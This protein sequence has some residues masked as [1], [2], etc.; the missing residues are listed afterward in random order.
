VVQI[1]IG[2]VFFSDIS[3]ISALVGTSTPSTMTAI[4]V[5]SLIMILTMYPTSF[6]VI[7]HDIE[8]GNSL[9]TIISKSIVSIPRTLEM[10]RADVSIHHYTYGVHGGNIRHLDTIHVESVDGERI[11]HLP[12][13]EAKFLIDQLKKFRFNIKTETRKMTYYTDFHRSILKF[14]F[15]LSLLLLSILSLL[16]FL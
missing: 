2:T 10:G 15:I 11:F 1:L 9:L 5:L 16:F 4:V 6:F 7:H 12:H 14:C 8:I 13:G 3:V